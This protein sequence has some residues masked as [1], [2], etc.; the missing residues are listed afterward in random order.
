MFNLQLLAPFQRDN[1][2]DTMIMLESTGIVGLMAYLLLILVA[3]KQIPTRYQR[4]ILYQPSFSIPLEI[5]L[6][7][8]HMHA[9]A[10]ILAISLIVMVQFDNTALSAGNFISVVL[11]LCV[12]LSGAVKREVRGYE[13]VCLQYHFLMDRHLRLSAAD[14]S[15]PYRIYSNQLPVRKS[16]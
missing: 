9:I 3:F 8:Y 11:W 14:L 2:N 5:D 16:S 13:Q 7:L 15:Q 10:F 12:A 6:T 1:V 4:W